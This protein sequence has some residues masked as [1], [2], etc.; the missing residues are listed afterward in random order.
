[1]AFSVITEWKISNKQEKTSSEYL[2][3]S[4]DPV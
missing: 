1:M 4:I 3:Y 2:E